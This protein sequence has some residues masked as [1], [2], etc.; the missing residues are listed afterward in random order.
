MRYFQTRQV[1]RPLTTACAASCAADLLSGTAASH[2][3][4]GCSAV[5]VIP[6]SK[7]GLSNFTKRGQCSAH[8]IWSRT[9]FAT[10]LESVMP[11]S[12][13]ESRSIHR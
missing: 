2:Q 12:A 11:P 9:I 8:G 5:H 7:N 3:S 1:P 10:G 13:V 4:S 6:P